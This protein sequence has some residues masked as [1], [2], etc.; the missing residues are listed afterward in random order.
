MVAR[1][2]A[3]EREEDLPVVPPVTLVA[4]QPATTLGTTDRDDEASLRA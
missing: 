1:G 4:D 2:E 3:V